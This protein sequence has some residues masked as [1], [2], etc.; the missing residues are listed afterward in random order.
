MSRGALKLVAAL[1]HFELDPA[2]QVC[3]DVGASTGGFSDVLRDQNGNPI[4]DQNGNPSATIIYTSPQPLVDYI[5]ALN[6]YTFHEWSL[7]TSWA[8]TWP[9]VRWYG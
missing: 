4:L 1:D 3:L 6:H 8:Q 7:T 9:R 5:N 2:G